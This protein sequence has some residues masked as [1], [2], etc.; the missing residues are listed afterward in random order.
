MIAA[1]DCP[2]LIDYVRDVFIHLILPVHS[3]RVPTA[4]HVI[5]EEEMLECHEVLLFEGYH[6]LIAQSKRHQLGREKLLMTH[7]GCIPTKCHI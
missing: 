5:F 6:H 4:I 3:I 1:V 7:R 2:Y